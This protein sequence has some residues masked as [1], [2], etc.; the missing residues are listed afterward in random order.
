MNASLLFRVS[1]S[2]LLF[3]GVVSSSIQPVTAMPL[4]QNTKAEPIK[5]PFLL[6]VRKTGGM[7]RLNSCDRELTILNNGTYR[8]EDATKT[9]A[10]KLS[11]R[12]FSRLKQR[13]A[14]LNIEQVR[15]QPFTGTC[16]IA[17][18]G[19]E[20][21]YRFLIGQTVEE[22]SDCKSAI[23]PGDPLFQQINQLY[24]KAVETV[25]RAESR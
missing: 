1:I 10:G 2:L 7:C 21:L 14:K 22:I 3:G 25:Y 12:A 11:R 20:T 16:P 9:G 15:S 6:K 17:Y 5:D 23:D 8:Y 24:D 18:D 4:I 13:L 19:P